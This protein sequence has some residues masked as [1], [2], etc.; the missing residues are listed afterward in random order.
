MCLKVYEITLYPIIAK[1]PRRV[2]V[3]TISNTRWC[4]GSSPSNSKAVQQFDVRGKMK[5]LA[6]LEPVLG[7]Q[8]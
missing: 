2:V 5:A 8:Y 1:L 4:F 3:Q 6:L 7:P